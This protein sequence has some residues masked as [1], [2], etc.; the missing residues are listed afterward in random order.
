[1]LFNVMLG[2]AFWEDRCLA[3][4]SIFVLYLE[5]L[6]LNGTDISMRPVLY[7]ELFA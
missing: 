2:N 1:M 4:I 5:Y 3:A 7:F 6:L